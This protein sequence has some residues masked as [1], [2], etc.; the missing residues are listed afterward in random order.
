MRLTQ[1][2]Y[3]T[4]TVSA[5]LRACH[6]SVSQCGGGGL[7][8]FPGA[9]DLSVGLYAKS[10]YVQKSKEQALAGWLSW[11]EQ[12]PRQQKGCGFDSQ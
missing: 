5:G 12:H 9:Q 4:G 6:S 10:L 7:S 2:K 1:D 3:P 11:L 8:A